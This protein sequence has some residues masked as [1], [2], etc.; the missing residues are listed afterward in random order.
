MIK[1]LYI[2]NY[3]LIQTL[4]LDFESGLTAFTGETGAGKSIIVGALSLLFGQ[5]ADIQVIGPHADD[6]EIIAICHIES[7]SEADLWLKSQ[8]LEHDGEIEIRRTIHKSGRSKIW[9][10][11]KPST[12]KTIQQLGEMVLQIHGQHDQVKLLQPAQQLHIV[13]SYGDFKQLLQD[14]NAISDDWR[15]LQK[16]LEGL[17]NSG[18]LSAEQLQLLQY[19]FEELSNL[20][21]QENEYDSLHKQLEQATHAV[22][23]KSSLT[24]AQQLLSNGDLNASQILNNVS[25][26]LSQTKGYDFSSIIGMLSEASINIEEA[27]AEIGLIEQN[28][29][30]DPQTLQTVEQRLDQIYS[31]GR[32]QKIEPHQ[33]YQ[34]TQELQ[35]RLSKHSE[36]D[37]EKQ[38]L[39]K[40]IQ[41]SLDQ[42]HNL[43]KQLHKKRQKAAQALATEISKQVKTLGLADAQLKIEVHR[44][45]DK[46]PNP[47][48]QDQVEFTV[49]I[50]KGQSFQSLSKTASGGEL[51]RI[52][53]AI[54]VSINQQQSG[55]F[56]FDEV[57]TGVGGATA[58]MIGQLM[59]Q[60]G[61][62]NQVF[63]VTHLPQVAGF[64][65]QHLQ[66]SKENVNGITQSAVAVLE[67]EQR[68]HE[69]ARM[70]GGQNITETTL[71]QAREFL[72]TG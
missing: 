32:K 21:L 64:A 49:A 44:D 39:E 70:S 46:T 23:L 10:G 24:Q 42:F 20:E 8:E 53:L 67:H 59:Q 16:Q 1:S 34:H 41:D 11:G 17:H 30:D 56:V 13:D 5:R 40:A 63:A 43:A 69:L 50:N 60:L 55:T 71:A 45:S 48:G 19:Q 2:R 65:D 7:G 37:S 58:E 4:D 22:E 52:A 14:I 61:H 72:K 3:V 38:E 9:L 26:S 47:L 15:T 36:Q 68:I 33:L 35:A 66:V 25:Q 51:S 29:D 62:N 27:A 31:V 57:D 28:I 12:N 54:E 18:S 6:A